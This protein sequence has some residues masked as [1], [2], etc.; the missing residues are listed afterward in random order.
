VNSVRG[1]PKSDSIR[2]RPS[3]PLLQLLRRRL[4]DQH[5]ASFEHGARGAQSTVARRRELASL[6]ADRLAVGGVEVVTHTSKAAASWWL[7]PML[8]ERP[9][10]LVRE[11]W[12]RGFD[13]TCSSTQLKSVPEVKEALGVG[14]CCST[15]ELMGRVVYLPITPELPRWA[16]EELAAAVLDVRRAREKAGGGKR[17][18]PAEGYAAGL[19]A[20]ALAA[21]LAWAPGA[22][23]CLVPT[24]GFLAKAA[25]AALLGFVVL[26]VVMRRLAADPSLQVTPEVLEHLTLRDRP[27]GLE[28]WRRAP[29]IDGRIDGAVLLTGSTGFVGGGVLFS[30]LARAREL[31]VTRIVLLIRAKSGAGAEARLAELRQNQAFEE[32]RDVFDELVV[33]LEGD[34]AQRGFG[35]GDES[36][37]WPYPEKL[38]AVLHC[39]GDVRFD[40]PLQ[41]AA[42]SLISASLQVAQLSA[43]WG[44]RRFVFVSTAFVHGVP[45]ATNF[46]QESLEQITITQKTTNT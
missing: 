15:K 34:V 43:Q 3:L 44:A 16:A 31:G 27:Q 41:Q 19:L 10:D 17:A 29:P 33:A 8:D 9:G 21:A 36:R 39:A 14:P 25:A 4:Q 40:Q 6:V 7:V 23:L 18:P 46:L 37:P 28:Y 11:L 42:L 12:A 30:L 5:K 45:S 22:V 35:W 26:V 13:A 20:L 32:V 1:F 2:Q 38:G 24:V